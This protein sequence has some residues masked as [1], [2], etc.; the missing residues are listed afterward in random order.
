MNNFPGVL[1]ESV[2]KR[3]IQIY[4]ALGALHV[5]CFRLSKDSFFLL[6]LISPK[7]NTIPGLCHLHFFTVMRRCVWD[8]WG[9]MCPMQIPTFLSCLFLS[10]GVE[11]EV[12]PEMPIGPRPRPLSDTQLKE[13]AIPIPE[14]KAF[15]FFTPTN[16][17]ENHIHT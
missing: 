17:Y 1:R 14:A 9:M 3:K 13:K 4:S 12:E 7:F 16:K 5:D 10:A 11:D 6:L 2:K 15:F 8:C